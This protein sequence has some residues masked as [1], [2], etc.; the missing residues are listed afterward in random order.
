MLFIC[1]V[2]VWILL[3]YCSLRF[4][5][6]SNFILISTCP[7]LSTHFLKPKSGSRIEEGCDALFLIAIFLNWGVTVNIKISVFFC[8]CSHECSVN[9]LFELMFQLLLLIFLIV[10]FGSLRNL[11]NKTL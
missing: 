4:S 11:L 5:F 8:F 2:F 10:S 1:K 3:T 9:T 6:S 7:N